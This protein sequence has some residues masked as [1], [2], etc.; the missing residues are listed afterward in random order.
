MKEFI[1]NREIE[2]KESTSGFRIEYETVNLEKWGWGVVYK[3]GTEL[4]QFD[5]EGI[6]HQFKEIKQDQVVMFTMYKTAFHLKEA[7]R[8]DMVITEGMKIMHFYRNIR[9]A[10]YDQFIKTYVFGYEKD[11]VKCFNFILP[12]DRVIVSSVDDIDLTKFNIT[13]NK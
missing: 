3:D 9:P 8:I 10:G 11:G 7:N 12:D 1:F 6:F 2:D 4:H 13:G 5:S